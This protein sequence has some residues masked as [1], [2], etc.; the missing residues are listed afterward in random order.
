MSEHMTPEQIQDTFQRW[1]REMAEQLEGRLPAG[2]SIMAAVPT[3]Q[4]AEACATICFDGIEHDADEAEH[5]VAGLIAVV[6]AAM[7]FEAGVMVE[8]KIREYHRRGVMLKADGI[9]RIA[10]SALQRMQQAHLEND[11]DGAYRVMDRS[12]D[13]PDNPGDGSQE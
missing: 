3:D 4:H 5:N 13:R 7:S 12:R 1:F 2:F 10:E 9:A 11:Y 8:R 6:Q